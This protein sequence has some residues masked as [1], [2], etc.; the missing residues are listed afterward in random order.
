MT[1]KQTISAAKSSSEKGTLKHYLK[2]IINK[3][4]TLEFDHTDV[5]IEE[6][7]ELRMIQ[8]NISFEDGSIKISHVYSDDFT[9]MDPTSESA[10]KMLRG[11]SP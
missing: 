8:S 6:E 11:E 9:G 1:D 4:K 7:V 2:R 3:V 10:L 5:I